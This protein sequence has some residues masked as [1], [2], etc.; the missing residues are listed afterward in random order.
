MPSEHWISVWSFARAVAEEYP[1]WRTKL[2]VYS[3][4]TTVAFSRVLARQ[5]FPSDVIVG[6]TFGNLIGGVVIHQ[7]AAGM[8]GISLSSIQ[9]ANGKGI[10]LFNSQNFPVWLPCFGSSRSRAYCSP[11]FRMSASTPASVTSM[12]VSRRRSPWL[13]DPAT[14]PMAE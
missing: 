7:R 1:G 6:S 10:Q 2:I 8:G 11:V 4:A 5:H 12:L 14:K 9:S 3:M 13:I